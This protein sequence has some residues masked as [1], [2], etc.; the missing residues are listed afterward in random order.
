MLMERNFQTIQDEKLVTLSIYIYFLAKLSPDGLK[1]APAIY[2]NDKR[3]ESIF[4][5]SALFAVVRAPRGKTFKFTIKVGDVQERSYGIA[6][7]RE[8]QSDHVHEGML[9]IDV[10]NML[11]N[12][13]ISHTSVKNESIDPFNNGVC[14]LAKSCLDLKI[15]EREVEVLFNK[16]RVLSSKAHMMSLRRLIGRLEQD[17]VVPHQNILPIALT[18]CRL[19]DSYYHFKGVYTI[20][21]RDIGID[22]IKKS[23]LAIQSNLSLIPM[24]KE[25][26]LVRSKNANIWR[27]FNL[28]PGFPALQPTLFVTS[29]AFAVKMS[30]E[31]M[32][33]AYIKSDEYRKCLAKMK[34]EEYLQEWMHCLSLFPDIAGQKHHIPFTLHA[35]RFK[36]EG[37]KIDDVI[38]LIESIISVPIDLKNKTWIIHFLEHLEARLKRQSEKSLSQ[39]VA[40]MIKTAMLLKDSDNLTRLF[41]GLFSKDC[42]KGTVVRLKFLVNTIDRATLLYRLEKDNILAI[43]D[44]MTKEL[45]YFFIKN[46]YDEEWRQDELIKEFYERTWS[47]LVRMVIDEAPTNQKNL[48]TSFLRIV[49]PP[50]SFDCDLYYYVTFQEVTSLFDQAFEMGVAKKRMDDLTSDAET[51]ANKIST[52]ALHVDGMTFLTAPILALISNL[53]PEAFSLEDDAKSLL[54]YSIAIRNQWETFLGA[55]RILQ[56]FPQFQNDALRNHTMYAKELHALQSLLV[57]DWY[58][59]KCHPQFRLVSNR[60]KQFGPSHFFQSLW[61]N[62][63]IADE[64]IAKMDEELDFSDRV[65][66]YFE[67]VF[68][69]WKELVES[70]SSGQLPVSKVESLFQ[71]KINVSTVTF[72]SKMSK[73]SEAEVRREMDT[74]RKKLKEDIDQTINQEIDLYL[75]CHK[76]GVALDRQVVSK[77]VHNCVLALIMAEDIAGLHRLLSH[78]DMDS[79]VI[80]EFCT[81]LGDA[82]K[83]ETTDYGALELVYTSL[84]NTHQTLV[85][86]IQGLPF[87][88]YYV[89]IQ[90]DLIKVLSLFKD[91]SSLNS[92]IDNRQSED[93]REETHDI[94]HMLRL[95]CERNSILHHKTFANIRSKTTAPTTINELIDFFRACGGSVIALAGLHQVLKKA[96]IQVIQESLQS[97]SEDRQTMAVVKNIMFNGS[98]HIVA[99]YGKVTVSASY[100][101]LTRN[102]KEKVNPEELD[103]LPSQ[104]LLT[105]GVTIKSEVAIDLDAP[106]PENIAR[107]EDRERY[108]LRF[109]M[110][111]DCCFRLAEIVKNICDA[112]Q[113]DYQTRDYDIPCDISST[114]LRDFI[115]KEEE[116][117]ETWTKYFDDFRVSCPNLS[118]LSRSQLV[119]CLTALRVQ[120]LDDLFAILQS[121]GCSP[122]LM[123]DKI[124]VSLDQATKTNKISEL[125]TILSNC[126]QTFFKFGGQSKVATQ[127][128]HTPLAD[129]TSHYQL[130]RV[131]STDHPLEEVVCG[132]HIALHKRIPCPVEMLFC[133]PQTTV[134][135]IEDFLDRWSLFPQTCKN[136]DATFWLVKIEDLAYSTQNRFIQKLNSLRVLKNHPKLFLVTQGIQQSYI[137]TIMIREETELSADTCTALSRLISP[138]AQSLNIM[139]VHSPGC[140]DGKTT[141]AIRSLVSGKKDSKGQ[142]VLHAQFSIDNTP[143][144]VIL[145]RLLQARPITSDRGIVLHL[146]IGHMVN[147]SHANL[148][149]FQYLLIASWRDNKGFTFPLH[150]KDTV[151]IELSNTGLPD[152]RKRIPICQYFKVLPIDDGITCSKPVPQRS[153]LSDI[154]YTFRDENTH[155][156]GTQMLVAIYNSLVSASFTLPYRNEINGLPLPNSKLLLQMVSAIIC[157][158]YC[159]QGHLMSYCN[160]PPTATTCFKCKGATQAQHA[161]CSKC[162]HALCH[163][164]MTK[165]GVAPVSTMMFFRRYFWFVVPLLENFYHAFGE[166][167]DFGTM[168]EETDHFKLAYHFVCIILKCTYNLALPSMEPYDSNKP[169]DD[170]TRGLNMKKFEDWREI[171]FM[172]VSQGNYHV[173][174]IGSFS[175]LEYI[176]QREPVTRQNSDFHKWVEQEG[177]VQPTNRSHLQS[178]CSK[179]NSLTFSSDQENPLL[180]NLLE[181]IGCS[182]SDAMQVLNAVKSIN[183]GDRSIGTMKLSQID[184]AESVSNSIQLL[185]LDPTKVSCTEFLATC[186]DYINNLF[187][188]SK[189]KPKYILTADNVLRILAVQTR[190]I[191]GIPICIMGETGCDKTE[192]LQFLSKITSKDF[193][194]INVQ[195]GLSEEDFYRIMEPIIQ[196]AKA[197]PHRQAIVV[198]D[199]VNT[200]ASLWIAKDMLVDHIC[201]GVRIPSNIVFVTVL[202]P[203]KERTEAQQR[204]I[205]SMDVGG[206]DFAKYQQ[207]HIKLASTDS[208]QQ[209]ATVKKEINLVYQVHKSPE[210][211]YSNAWDWGSASTTHSTFKEIEKVLEKD[212]L[213]KDRATISDELIVASSMVQWLIES[214][215]KEPGLLDNFRTAG[216]GT[217]GDAYW[218]KF[219]TI[220]VELLLVSQSFIRHDV[221]LD[222]ISVVSLRDMR[223]MCELVKVIYLEFWCETR[224]KL[225]TVHLDKP[226]P[227]FKFLTNAVQVALVNSY[228]LRLDAPRRHTYLVRIQTHW[229]NV[230]SRYTDIHHG[231]MENPSAL[232]SSYDTMELYSSFATYIAQGLDIDRGIAVNQ[233]LKENTFALLCS[234]MTKSPLFIVGRPGST[235]SRSLELLIRATDSNRREDSLLGNLG[236]VIQSHVIQCSPHTT[237][238]HIRTNALRA[239]RAQIA[240]DKIQNDTTKRINIIVLEEVGATIG[241]E[242]NPLMSLHDMIDNGIEVD[243]RYIKLP[244]I[245]VS[246]YR[247]DA[248]KM[249]RG[250]VVYRGNPPLK[251]LTLTAESILRDLGSNH[252]DQ[253]RWIENFSLS[254]SKNILTNEE[255][256]WYFG[257]RDFYATISTIR[258]LAMPVEKKPGLTRNTRTAKSEINSHITRWAVMINLRGYPVDEKE[259]D[260]AN[261]MQ[262]CFKLDNNVM[263]TYEWRSSKDSDPILLCDCCCHIMMYRKTL[264]WRTNNPDTEMTDDIQSAIFKDSATPLLHPN[265]CQYFDGD[266]L[267]VQAPEV[268]SY[269]LMET[270]SR[271]VMIFTK[272]NAA[273]LLLFS[274]G[275]V[276]KDQCT[277]IFQ[278]SS[279]KDQATT[280]SELVQQ[281]MQIKACMREGKTLVL[282]KSRHLYESMLDAL[283]V[284]YTKD[285]GGIDGEVLHKTM[286][287]MA[288]VTQSVFVKPSFRCIVLEDQK[289]LKTSVLPP[290]INR[291]SKTVL[292]FAS[293]LSPQQRKTKSMI[294]QQSEVM[295]KDNGKI[296]LLEFLVAGLNEQSFDS[297]VYTYGTVDQVINR[298]CYCFSR[299]NL[300]RLSLKLVEGFAS[301]NCNVP[302]NYWSEMWR[303]NVGDKPLERLAKEI[304][305][306]EDLPQQHLMVIT[307]QIQLNE[308]SLMQVFEPLFSDLDQTKSTLNI[309]QITI[310]NQTTSVDLSSVLSALKRTEANQHQSSVALFILDTTSSSQSILLDS[311]LSTTCGRR[312]FWSYQGSILNEIIKS[313]YLNEL[314]REKLFLHDVLTKELIIALA[315]LPDNL[316]TLCQSLGSST[317]VNQSFEIIK[318]ILTYDSL[319]IDKIIELLLNNIRQS[320]ITFERWARVAFQKARYSS[321]SL[322]SIYLDYLGPFVIRVLHHIFSVITQYQSLQLLDKHESGTLMPLTNSRGNLDVKFPLSPNIFV[323][324]FNLSLSTRNI[325]DVED[326]I[327][328]A[329]LDKL[330]QDTLAK[331]FDDVIGNGTTVPLSN[332][333]LFKKVVRASYRGAFDSMQSF[334]HLLI[335]QLDWILSVI[336]L[337]SQQFQPSVIDKFD[338]NSVQDI[339][340]LVRVNG[341][342]P[343]NRI[344]MV[345]KVT[346][347][348]QSID[349]SIIRSIAMADS[350]LDKAHSRQSLAQLYDIFQANNI[351]GIISLFKQE[352]IKYIKY[353]FFEL[354]AQD[355]HLGTEDTLAKILSE[356]SQVANLSALVDQHE[357]I[358]CGLAFLLRLSFTVILSHNTPTE[359]ELFQELTVF[360]DG[361]LQQYTLLSHCLIDVLFSDDIHPNLDQD[362][363]Q[364]FNDNYPLCNFIRI[365]TLVTILCG[366]IEDSCAPKDAV[367]YHPLI[368]HLIGNNQQLAR[369]M[370]LFILRS[371]SNGGIVDIEKAITNMSHPKIPA[372]LATNRVVEDIKRALQK[373]SPLSTFNQFTMAITSLAQYSVASTKDNLAQFVS[374][375][376]EG[377]I[378]SIASFV[379]GVEPQQ[380]A[381]FMTNVYPAVTAHLPNEANTALQALFKIKNSIGDSSQRELIASYFVHLLVGCK[382]MTYFKSLVQSLLDQ[383]ANITQHRIAIETFMTP[384]CPR[385]SCK[386]A[387][388]DWSGCFAVYCGCGCSFCGHC[389]EDCGTDAHSHVQQ[390]HGS[391]WGQYDQFRRGFGAMATTKIKNYLLTLTADTRPLVEALLPTILSGNL[392]DVKPQQC[393][394]QGA[395]INRIAE[396]PSV[397][398]MIMDLLVCLSKIWHS[399]ANHKEA[400]PLVNLLKE[401]NELVAKIKSLVFYAPG[402]DAS[403]Y[404][405]IQAILWKLSSAN[406]A[407]RNSVQNK[408]TEICGQSPQSLLQQLDNLCRT[409]QTDILSELQVTEEKL[410]R[411]PG[412]K[413][414]Q[415]K[416]SLLALPRTIITD[417]QIAEHIKTNYDTYPIRNLLRE[418]ELG[419]DKESIATQMRILHF[420][421]RLQVETRKSGVTRAYAST[422]GSF[423]KMVKQSGLEPDLK[424]FIIDFSTILK[425]VTNWQCRDDIQHNFGSMAVNL[426]NEVALQCFLPQLKENGIL[427]MCLWSGRSKDGSWSGIP[428]AQNQLY[429][430]IHGT[431]APRI[432]CSPYHLHANESL[433]NIDVGQI[434]SIIHQLF[435]IPGYHPVMSKD[436]FVIE[437]LCK[438]GAPRLASL[439]YIAPELPEYDYGLDGISELFGKLGT[440]LATESREFTTLPTGLTSR[441]KG[442]FGDIQHAADLI[443]SFCGAVLVY[444]SGD[445]VPLGKEVADININ[446]PLTE[447][448]RQGG[449]ILFEIPMA[450]KGFRID[451]IPAMMGLC[452]NIKNVHP[453][454]NVPL[455]DDAKIEIQ[456]TFAMIVGTPK[457]HKQI[458]RILT[459]LR[460]AG[461]NYFINELNHASA[462][463]PLHHF[464]PVFP[465]FEDEEDQMLERYPFLTCAK[466]FGYILQEA[467]SILG[468]K[469]FESNVEEKDLIPIRKYL[470][471][472]L[473]EQPKQPASRMDKKYNQII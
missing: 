299:K 466:H 379:M 285:T 313:S 123:R 277:V 274:M 202:N 298:L 14:F 245:G 142:P 104:L 281:M 59:P 13:M 383:K 122:S 419:I 130:V 276:K 369:E 100:I 195:E 4:E 269:S 409:G 144:D 241:S 224:A 267:T 89:M 457:Y 415:T 56:N 421:D 109:N 362:F 1:E 327:K 452:W 244:I 271:H 302:I 234:V 85:Q 33:P 167:W 106:L 75:E 272:A 286:L 459:S 293:A 228:C 189:D 451:N 296:D 176:K 385:A 226:F 16:L 127:A 160:L 48:Q 153:D 34:K 62:D 331:Y 406:I 146:N 87:L 337:S 95:L 380:I 188:S 351:N 340:D 397:T 319:I 73:L 395:N 464:L 99:N 284:H 310:L 289:E 93:I 78:L 243:G 392:F 435:V 120:N 67:H 137:S 328:R 410:M 372:L 79:P 134:V 467:E 102:E 446:M 246:N 448:Q 170:V 438:Y 10:N 326:F 308:R 197:N 263:A 433:I 185:G 28:I 377:R 378:S 445:D 294:L 344:D 239:A 463:T 162:S 52:K 309:Q 356:L 116:A 154:I 423:I 368:Q 304:M 166:R 361:S 468:P 143:M 305:E 223:K 65:V 237:A 320:D 180:V 360:M 60:L 364:R 266:N 208:Q 157:Q 20:E 193:T 432:A 443:Y 322:R 349:W 316:T 149:L 469:E 125:F 264:V 429:T 27:Y 23:F 387:F 330:P 412:D 449:Q 338:I 278:S 94:L 249:G 204:S 447:D 21:D 373:V 8:I 214:L 439:P 179:L 41:V 119:S 333:S 388:V 440:R 265:F 64:M 44:I 46:L 12:G 427:P 173:T 458:P 126:L 418:Q 257:M 91:V 84:T 252:N 428:F 17:P 325:Q 300:R 35:D 471:Q 382:P 242:H 212:I 282:V 453:T 141:S 55:F 36:S 384:Q 50:G 205:A 66:E 292:T 30:L 311:F 54:A 196:R 159:Q 136:N 365:N 177:L 113:P 2:V 403:T 251:D 227:Y 39:Y 336:T 270:A 161:H 363:I 155:E 18:L 175:P 194:I 61:N 150:E 279:S 135:D 101:D 341:I 255:F 82:N 424:S 181:I 288:G 317:V 262:D 358:K 260:L 248:S 355:D 430:I 297:V 216:D 92:R 465:A 472:N 97:E 171:P 315:I 182:D 287:S 53:L 112:G 405:Y 115:R 462:E 80:N 203:W 187:G 345:Q 366:L 225:E 416:L 201:F 103:A 140:S 404:A 192:T 152:E 434:D 213:I 426:S 217:L 133:T 31:H 332:I 343:L 352:N 346:C 398:G 25:Y 178:L 32:L 184:Q 357:D 408:V 393:V 280:T 290:M 121:V 111:F 151:I 118:L 9:Y 172:V 88:F 110:M 324:L 312:R 132:N 273:L 323:Y 76:T 148:F 401:L 117:L 200:T 321:D 238:H 456:E 233:A 291:F 283:N 221:Y 375:H 407:D 186:T 165:P 359:S 7:S 198:L 45:L 147:R 318:N 58:E 5:N 261:G 105:S 235:K 29:V 71:H 129:I 138:I 460:I 414:D 47:R 240:A 367:Q 253:S 211:L 108:V 98:I 334:H 454:A 124:Q 348:D 218:I 168:I 470:K 436:L 169:S 3:V 303:L 22:I 43:I 26:C 68:N 40:S 390:K 342:I 231:F 258:T 183:E 335:E 164:C 131:V 158:N 399:T 215:R 86:V 199:E 19:V 163:N 431:N 295:I 69:S 389:L 473:I 354:F 145:R 15:F 461:C 422:E 139:V 128:Y 307:E 156:L 220:M 425:Q 229:T 381:N 256:T 83:R 230:R 259:K 63:A 247:L 210:T 232:S 72:R 450:R 411:Q 353:F 37:N 174:S 90:S 444:Q 236:I 11:F 222:E 206:L 347:D 77:R 70:I 376:Q 254:F 350:S 306:D 81:V 209:Q 413:I 417:H 400:D 250:R 374:L 24:A 442:I 420:L 191:A 339:L 74:L 96:S 386:K 441:L 268:I 275:L 371:Y 396:V 437:D 38:P 402:T 301:D 314:E 6:S 49:R 42:N 219:R 329:Q 57:T 51:F 114:E 394:T 107:P 207:Q 190:L 370:T 455:D 391:Y